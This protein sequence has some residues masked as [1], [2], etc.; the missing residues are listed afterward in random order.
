MNSRPIMQ[1]YK[2]QTKEKRTQRAKETQQAGLIYS[3]KIAHGWRPS[4]KAAEEAEEVFP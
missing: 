4:L 1:K 3:R 2:I